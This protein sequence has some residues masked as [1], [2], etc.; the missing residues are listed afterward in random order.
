MAL[1]IDLKSLGP[2]HPRTGNDYLRIARIYDSQK[3]W[4]FSKKYLHI[5]ADVYQELDQIVFGSILNDIAVIHLACKEY[6]IALE[7]FSKVLALYDKHAGD[8]NL[9]STDTVPILRNIAECL[10]KQEKFEKA[11]LALHNALDLQRSAR[12]LNDAALELDFHA[13]EVSARLIDDESIADTMR[14]IGKTC[15]AANQ[16]SESLRLYKD[17]MISHRTA[18]ADSVLSGDHLTLVEKQDQ[19]AHTLY[20]IA[21][22]YHAVSEFAGALRIYEESLQLRIDSDGLRSEKKNLIHCS[23]CLVG[24]A[25]N[26]MKQRDYLE[27]YHLYTG[28]LSYCDQQGMSFFLPC[29]VRCNDTILTHY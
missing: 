26:H 13:T 5:S 21:E 7:L 18:V 25:N 28:A 8:K 11:K 16:Y 1:S 24:M 23:M 22:V 6:N 14:R 2:R 15:F 17:A 3:Q 20:C 4:D 29:I 10:F 9:G 12:K 27:A 19:L